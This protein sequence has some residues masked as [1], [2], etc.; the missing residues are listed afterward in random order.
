[1][2]GRPPCH[3]PGPRPLRLR[4][5]QGEPLARG[6]VDHDGPGGGEAGGEVPGGG[7]TDSELACEGGG[8]EWADS[9]PDGARLEALA[10]AS[11][12]TFSWAEDDVA[13]IPLPPPTVISA[14]RHTAPIAPPWVWT[15]LASLLLGA[16]WIVR[17]RGGLP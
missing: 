12:G 3:G 6:V 5:A 14:E 13:K 8:D 7:G 4:S 10:K 11:G 2:H 17:R 1:M 9:R 15:V 16:H